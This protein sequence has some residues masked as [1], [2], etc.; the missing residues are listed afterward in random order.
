MK[1]LN[2]IMCI[3]FA[4]MGV[5][6]TCVAICGK[7]IAWGFFAFILFALAWVAWGDYKKAR[8]DENTI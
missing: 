4:V 5:A 6:S 7:S 8:D 1:A 2:Y 3:G